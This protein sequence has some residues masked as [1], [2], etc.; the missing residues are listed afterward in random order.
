[1]NI[2]G[3]RYDQFGIVRF[4]MGVFIWIKHYNTLLI[5]DNGITF[6]IVDF[7]TLEK[8][9]A[10][11]VTFAIE[12]GG[13]FP[14]CFFALSGL[15]IFRG[16]KRKIAS[17][18]ITFEEYLS[19]RVFRLFPTMF[20]SIILM[21][22]GQWI[23]FYTYREWWTGRNNDLWHTFISLSGVSVGTFSN[24]MDTVNGPIWYISVLIICYILFWIITKLEQ[25]YVCGVKVYFLPILVGIAILDYEINL[26]FLTYTCGIGYVGFFVGVLLAYLMENSLFIKYLKRFS[27]GFICFLVLSTFL[28]RSDIFALM[29]GDYLWLVFIAFPSV[30]VWFDKLSFG[31][32]INVIFDYLGRLNF[33]MYLFQLPIFLLTDLVKQKYGVEDFASQPNRLFVDLLIIILVSMFWLFILPHVERYFRK[34]ATGI[35]KVITL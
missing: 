23:W 9:L 15:L 18:S 24:T 4:L 28:Y 17:K 11:I 32:V 2:K 1:M 34:V 33:P 31:R 6:E 20:M 19:K 21:S 26:P 5:R 35:K 13:R 30:I 14:I 27:I 3:K 22:I 16:Y 10:Y 29:G 12:I 25:K 7:P 8:I